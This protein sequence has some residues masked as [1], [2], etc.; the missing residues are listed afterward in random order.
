MVLLH[1]RHH[2]LLASLQLLGAANRRLSRRLQGRVQAPRQPCLEQ[3]VAAVPSQLKGLL[4]ATHLRWAGGNQAKRRLTV[5]APW[6]QGGAR[7]ESPE[8]NYRP[9]RRQGLGADLMATTSGEQAPHNNEMQL[10]KGQ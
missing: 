5:P 8:L 1:P 3:A 2:G 4:Q 7:A 9:E 10:T 6:V